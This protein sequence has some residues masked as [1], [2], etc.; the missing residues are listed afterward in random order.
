M[1][2][3]RNKKMETEKPTGENKKKKSKKFKCT[4]L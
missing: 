1:R 4:I 2:M 3:I